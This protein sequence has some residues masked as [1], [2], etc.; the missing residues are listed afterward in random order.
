MEE[1]FTDSVLKQAQPTFGDAIEAFSA[2]QSHA[3][4]ELFSSVYVGTISRLLRKTG[5]IAG[6]QIPKLVS[7]LSIDCSAFLPHLIGPIKERCRMSSDSA[8]A[9]ALDILRA[10]LKQSSDP[11][12]VVDAIHSIASGLAGIAFPANLT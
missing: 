12:P 1:I 9:D 5:D 2:L 3:S 4:R 8:R 7:N 6:F 10:L 11:A